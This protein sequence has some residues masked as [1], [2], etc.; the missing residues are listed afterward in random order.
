MRTTLHLSLPAHNINTRN[1]NTP[2]ALDTLLRSRISLGSHAMRCSAAALL[3]MS[4]CRA[5]CDGSQACT[6][7]FTSQHRAPA[8][9]ACA[10]A[11]AA[12][13]C[14]CSPAA[15]ACACAQAGYNLLHGLWKYSWDAD[16]ELF[17]KILQGQVREDVYF[18]QTDLQART[19]QA[20]L[21]ALLAVSDNAGA[22]TRAR[23]PAAGCAS[24]AHAR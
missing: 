3:P 6:A 15:A 10:C 23:G 11:P 17:L 21:H 19:G 18:Q 2:G 8:A 4:A 14:A 12:A 16:C 5:T 1:I 13:A 24:P 20:H 7:A 22:R 9:A